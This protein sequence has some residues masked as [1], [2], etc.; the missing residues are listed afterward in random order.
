M[1]LFPEGFLWGG[2]ISGNQWEGGWQAG[3][4]GL[5][6]ADV[7]RYKP[8]VDR[9]NYHALHSIG[10]DEILAATKSDDTLRYPTRHGV[11]GYHRWR[12]DVDLLAELGLKVLRV[13]IQWTR[14]FPRGDESEPNEAGLAFYDEFFGYL[15]EKGIEILATLSWYDQPLQ[16]SF[17][18]DGWYD[19]VMIEHFVRYA[20]T[21]YA[22]YGH[23][24]KFWLTFNEIDSVFR[25]PWS[26]LGHCE[27]HYPAERRE[28]MIYQSVHNQF[29][30]SALATKAL[31]KMAPEAQMGC[32]IT[33]TTTYPLDCNPANMLK[34]QADNRENL[35]YSDVQVRGHYPAWV[36]HYWERAGI[37]VDFGLDDE[38]KGSY[39]RTCKK[40]CWW[41]Q[42]VIASNGQQL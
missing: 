35:F 39:D 10:W 31:H 15:H 22:R 24:V 38:G 36:R 14:L 7:T 41:Y 30:A 33:R 26:T 16:V 20:T 12:E 27:D 2:G 1:T 13:G 4:K 18:C 17:D 23:L 34:A 40:S 19:R 29:V 21:Y 11:D 42:R 9:T 5:S 32:M 25:Q 8:D 37:H 28:E 3:G 6:V